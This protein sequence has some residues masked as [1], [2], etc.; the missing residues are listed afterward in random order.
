M[1][2]LGADTGV[3]GLATLVKSSVVLSVRICLIAT[4]QR[5]DFQFVIPLL[6]VEGALRTGCGTL[7]ARIAGDTHV[8]G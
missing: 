7:V 4:I 5:S 1:D 6:A 2:S 3:G 8:C